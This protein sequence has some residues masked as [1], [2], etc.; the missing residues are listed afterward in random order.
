MHEQFKDIIANLPQKTTLYLSNFTPLEAFETAKDAGFTVKLLPST[1]QG[2][3]DTRMIKPFKPKDNVAIIAW[4][5]FHNGEHNASLEALQST[6]HFKLFTIDPKPLFQLQ[7]VQKIFK[8]GLNASVDLDAGALTTADCFIIY[9]RPHMFCPKEGIVDALKNAD[10]KF[11]TQL[12]ALY[13]Q[14]YFQAEKRSPMTAHECSLSFIAFDCNI[15]IESAHKSVEVILK[16]LDQE[17]LRRC[18]F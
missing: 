14:E 17:A 11:H 2:L 15:S 16:A 1:L 13:K 5:F 8:E 7:E 18:S 12:D 6:H 10:V 3:I 4:P 9:L